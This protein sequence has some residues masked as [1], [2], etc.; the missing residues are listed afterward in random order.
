MY[1]TSEMG[2]AWA[3]HIFHHV[4]C[5]RFSHVLVKTTEDKIIADAVDSNS[6]KLF[7]VRSRAQNDEDDDDDGKHRN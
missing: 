7:I 5:F 4:I 3:P 6:H 1:P 2:W